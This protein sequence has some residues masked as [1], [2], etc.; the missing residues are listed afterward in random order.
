MPKRIPPSGQHRNSIISRRELLQAGSVTAAATSTAPLFL[1]ASDKSGSKKPII[2]HGEHTY[3]CE[4]DWGAESLT[5]GQ[6]YG[7]ASHGTAVDSEG[8]VYITH[9]GAPGSLF[10]FDADGQFI[11]SM[12]HFHHAGG[13]AQSSGHGI[14]IRKEDG[15]EFVYLAA[16]DKAMDFAKMTLNGEVVWRKGRKAIHAD[17][18]M[19][20]QGTAYR[21][22]N[23]S[24][25]PDGGYFLGDGYGS[26]YIFQYDKNGNYLRT[27]GGPGNQNGRFK[28]P[29][30]Q[31]LD[32]RDGTPKLVVAD[33]ANK[34]LQWFDME[35]NHLKTLGGF[36]FPADIDIQGK[37]LMVPDLHCRITLLDENNQ[38]IVQLGED[39]KWR[40]RALDGFKMRTK[41]AEW[42]PGKFVHPHDAC[43]DEHGNIFVAEWV[44]TGRV[45]KLRKVS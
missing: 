39:S 2:G 15:E 30:G 27:L 5:R 40:T 16:A 32:N 20:T 44:E 23:I 41:R 21:P 38:V 3:E 6:H 29:H 35:G 10:V 42:L 1:H 43:F 7:G 37:I 26:N 24:F 36:L 33:R 25:S 12:G 11:R 18:G 4:H 19:Y 31:W 13:A 28:T 17:S 14:D 9:R 22:T 8:R 45:S 34:R